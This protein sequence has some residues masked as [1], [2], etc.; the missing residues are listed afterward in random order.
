MFLKSK[1][2]LR[3]AGH[4]KKH[5]F[6]TFSGFEKFEKRV[7]LKSVWYAASAGDLVANFRSLVWGV[8]WRGYPKEWWLPCLER[9]LRK[10]NLMG[11]ISLGSVA[12]WVREGK[13]A[14]MQSSGVDTVAH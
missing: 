5:G 8:G 11:V 3:N 1:G 10:Y 6:E 4:W 14:H 2:F 9:F 12:T 7:F 13:R